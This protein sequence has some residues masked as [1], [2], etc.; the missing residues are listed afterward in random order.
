MSSSS[1]YDNWYQFTNISHCA[2]YLHLL[3]FLYWLGMFLYFP[4]EHGWDGEDSRDFPPGSTD[5]AEKGHGSAA[6]K[7]NDGHS[8][9]I[10][11]HSLGIS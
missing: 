6:E 7:D 4:I 10:Y 1:R 5:G 2:Y 9:C 8:E 11:T 3:L